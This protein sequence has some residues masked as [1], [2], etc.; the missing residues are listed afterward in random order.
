MFYLGRHWF[1]AF[2]RRHPTIA[3]R[4]SQNLTTSRASVTESS[5]RKWFDEIKS[6]ISI[7]GY[8]PVLEDPSRIFNMDETAF[9]L[10]PKEKKVLVRKGD[11]AVYSFSSNDDKECVTVLVAGSA[12]GKIPP[13]MV[14]FAYKRIPKNIVNGTPKEW[15]LGISDNGWMTGE[16]FYEYVSNVFY[17][18]VISNGIEL[19]IILFVDGHTSHMTLELSQFC[20]DKMI[21]LVALHPN[22]T[23]ILQ[24]MDVAVFHP[25]KSNWRVAVHKW[26]VENEQMRLTKVHFPKLLQ[27][28]L[29]A[30]KPQTLQN[31]FRACGLFPLD[32]N[33]VKYSKI[34]K[35]VKAVENVTNVQEPQEK[36]N[37]LKHF[38][39][40]IPEKLTEFK[41]SGPTWEGNK[42]DES[43][44]NLWKI[45]SAERSPCYETTSTY[46]NVDTGNIE[47]D[48]FNLPELCST[49]ISTTSILNRECEDLPY[50]R[51]LVLE[52]GSNFV[53]DNSKWLQLQLEK[54]NEVTL[55]EITQHD[56][57]GNTI[58]G[59]INSLEH[60]GMESTSSVPVGLKDQE[61]LTELTTKNL[62][63]NAPATCEKHLD[64][65]SM[66]PR[67]GPSTE[68]GNIPQGIMTPFKQTLFWPKKKIQVF[69]T[70]RDKVPAVVTSKVWL[71]YFQNKEDKKE[72]LDADKKAK[73]SEKENKKQV[74]NKIKNTKVDTAKRHLFEENKIED[75][76]KR[77]KL[78]LAVGSYVIVVY[79]GEYFPGAIRHVASNE[80]LITV[81]AMSGINSWKWPT[82]EDTVWYK[83]G[84]IL[85]VISEPTPINQR[86]SF[87]VSE[88]AK[89]RKP[90]KLK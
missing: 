49:P 2:L 60:T 11:K 29:E 84:Q 40:K 9:F 36:S 18:W 10:S 88:I 37:F 70:R 3:Q 7:N 89:Y 41:K 19:P 8:S 61:V 6:Y 32:P 26:R 53:L 86:G 51:S 43:L 71:D 25:L 45:I 34:I 50:E 12:S 83:M 20:S 58:Q 27:S 66:T 54:N 28:V 33:A 39:T 55:T 78:D 24:P 16:T 73:K 74:K 57:E 76:E 69:K 5:I 15:G 77:P 56:L 64:I 46:P 23:H 63:I 31:G 48:Q 52:I 42:S 30:V 13:P 79:E 75:V 17:P 81:M 65:V 21:I 22:A 62:D 4:V 67:P 38:E 1:E 80:C 14:L 44:F 68:H 59:N 47:N 72:K 85:E 90:V 35:G 82:K 87:M